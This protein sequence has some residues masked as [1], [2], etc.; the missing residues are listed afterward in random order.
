MSEG[1]VNEEMKKIHAQNMSLRDFC[2]ACDQMAKAS[3]KHLMEDDSLDM[4]E[5]HIVFTHIIAE[6]LRHDEI[7]P[8]MHELMVHYADLLIEGELDD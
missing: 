5:A 2:D 3:L 1:W 7:A 6:K 4:F 8:L